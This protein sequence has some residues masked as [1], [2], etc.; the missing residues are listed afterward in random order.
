MDYIEHLKNLPDIDPT[1]LTMLPLSQIELNDGQLDGLPKNPR[2]IKKDKFQKLKNNIEAYPEMLAWRSLLVYP[3]D[4]GKYIIIGG[5]MRYR[6]MTE[7]GHTE[8]PVFIIPKDTPVDRLQ[9]YTIIDNNGFGDWEWDLLANEWPDDM[10]ADWGLDVPNMDCLEEPEELDGER[11]TK[12][13]VAKLTFK[14][15][16]ALNE[17]QQMYG[18]QLTSEYDCIISVSGGKL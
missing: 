12:A 8:A 18:E 7:L 10:L 2:T 16:A 4:N 11:E 17:F 15:E 1:K 5:N 3:L 14:S 6:A 13:F 9:A